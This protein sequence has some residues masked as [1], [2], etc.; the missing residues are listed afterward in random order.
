VYSRKT[1][2]KGYQ[3]AKGNGDVLNH[4][5]TK[6]LL[7]STSNLLASHKPDMCSLH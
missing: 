6:V 4:K 7:L 3:Q 5:P 2:D 1:V